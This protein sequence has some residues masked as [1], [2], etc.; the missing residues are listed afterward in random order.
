MEISPRM[1]GSCNRA[2]RRQRALRLL[3][4]RL[5][6][7]L[8][9]LS[10]I[11]L[12]VSLPDGLSLW[13][14][15]GLPLFLPAWARAKPSAGLSARDASEQCADPA[16]AAAATV[17]IQIHRESCAASERNAAMTLSASPRAP[18]SWVRM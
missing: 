7:A 9:R 15:S 16:G 11:L 5:Y 18:G 6:R 17:I 8:V 13:P 2:G 14:G 12:S 4:R 10:S 3:L 1:A